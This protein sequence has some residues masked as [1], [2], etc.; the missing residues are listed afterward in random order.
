MSAQ[1]EVPEVGP[2]V[3]A[4]PLCGTAVAP[5][6]ASCES[7]GYHL[8][9]VEARPGPYNRTALWWTGAALAIVYVVTLLVVLAAR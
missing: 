7:C 2:I 6:A 1:F 5:D 8:S 3:E 9:G 4:C